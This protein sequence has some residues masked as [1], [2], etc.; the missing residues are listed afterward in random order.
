MNS[1][2]DV[3]YVRIL[4]D[5]PHLNFSF[6]ET[7]S[8][9]DPENTSYQESLVLW[10]AAPVAFILVILFLASC[11]LCIQ[12]VKKK[13]QK[14]PRTTCLRVVVAIFIIF[15]VGAISVGFFGNEQTSKGAKQFL[16]ALDDTNQTLEDVSITLDTLAD[17]VDKVDGPAGVEAL[18]DILGRSGDVANK[19][20][21]PILNKIE[22]HAKQ[23]RNDIDNVKSHM[24]S[25][26]LQK[27]SKEAVDVEFIR[28][29]VTI[30]LL[31]FALFILLTT[32][33]GCYKKSRCLLMTSVTLG[34]FGLLL[35]WAGSGTYLG[36]SVGMS[37]LCYDP[38]SFVESLGKDQAQK[39]VIK[40]YS[41]CQSSKGVPSIFRK[42]IQ[43]AVQEVT[44]ANSTLNKFIN[45]SSKFIPVG[46]IS[47]P[48]LHL[49][50][51]FDYA[52]GNV[53]SLGELLGC[54]T[55]HKDY[56]SAVE[57]VCE[58]ALVGVALLLLMLPFAGICMI[59]V[60]CLLPRVW[61]LAGKRRGYRP[62]DD[63]DPFCH[64]PPPYNGYGTM[65][66]G[67]GARGS[68]TLEYYR[69]LRRSADE[70]RSEERVPMNDSPP[71]AYHPGRFP[72]RYD[73][74]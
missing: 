46:E 2:K 12:C 27:F 32:S 60:Q 5:F 71:P 41:Q 63:S 8:T 62:V 6:R 42:E 66:G 52:V 73:L 45:E 1:Y 65:E 55:L 67:G 37:D 64:R 28:W 53:T 22:E 47:K 72:A 4:H 9:F 29:T 24:P 50:T 13:P 58:T 38:D 54:R 17:V 74:E 15:S 23:T 51:Q 43:N 31:C 21:S 40:E 36:L 16:E 48:V 7:N 44:E 56:K 19:T 14:P 49:R 11:C 30:V 33:L 26:L 59:I 39:D 68:C 25:L 61:Y 57:G 20:L 10:A 18:K 3:W 69:D 34:F 70:L 35:V